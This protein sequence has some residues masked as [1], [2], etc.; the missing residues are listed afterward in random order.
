MGEI[1]PTENLLM[2]IQSISGAVLVTMSVAAWVFF[3]KQAALSVFLGGGI[4][5][6]SFQILK[7]QLRRALQ[8]PGGSS[9]KAGLFFSYY[10]RYF[11]S[12]FLVFLFIYLGW[13]DP[14][15]FLAGLSTVV[16]SVVIVGGLEYLV[17]FTKRGDG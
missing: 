5:I 13:V 16:M 11:G 4:V 8:K 17:S 2:R 7:W 14:L 6:L 10:L 15:A 3:S 1:V 12:L 9:S